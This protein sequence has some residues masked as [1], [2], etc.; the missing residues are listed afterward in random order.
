MLCHDI[1]RPSMDCMS[2]SLNFMKSY[3]HFNSI[4]IEIV[5]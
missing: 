5:V 1:T 4:K 2:F 3:P